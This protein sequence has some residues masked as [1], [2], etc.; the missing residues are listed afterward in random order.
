MDELQEAK[1][2]RLTKAEV[3]QIKANIAKGEDVGKYNI[4]CICYISIRNK[5]GSLIKRSCSY[6]SFSRIFSASY[7]ERSL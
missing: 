1:K 3:Q 6:S 7:P 4:N 2:F 5:P